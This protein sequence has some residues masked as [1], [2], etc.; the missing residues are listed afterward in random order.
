MS[1]SFERKDVCV[2]G[3]KEGEFQG[4]FSVIAGSTNEVLRGKITPADSRENLRMSAL[5]KV[6]MQVRAVLSVCLSISRVLLV[7]IL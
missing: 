6:T 5:P 4:I 3:K 2:P 1:L 7:A